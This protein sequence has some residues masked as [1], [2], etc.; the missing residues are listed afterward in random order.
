MHSTPA[1]VVVDSHAPQAPSATAR[2]GR[3]RRDVRVARLRGGA[4]GSGGRRSPDTRARMRRDT[5]R[6]RGGGDPATVRA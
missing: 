6:C 3:G 4:C 2:R 1:H 5:V